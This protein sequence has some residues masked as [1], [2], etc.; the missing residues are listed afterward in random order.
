METDPLIDEIRQIR[1][2]ISAE[3]NHDTNKMYAYYKQVEEK[4]R[5]SGQYTILDTDNRPFS[6]SQ[7]QEI[8]K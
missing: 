3:F 5:T 8:D 2:K 7:R 1:H 4:L 6:V